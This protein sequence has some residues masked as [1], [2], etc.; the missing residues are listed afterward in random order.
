M[1]L[2]PSIEIATRLTR[3]GKLAEAMA[4][5]TGTAPAGEAGT[6]PQTP[7]EA[8]ARPRRVL[9]A[10]LGTVIGRLA[11]GGSL[12]SRD[13]RHG[14]SP[15]PEG[16]SFTERHM[17]S[18]VGLTYKL[19]IPS[20]AGAEPLPLLV[21]LHGCTQSP[22][23]F[24]AGT[25][26]NERAEAEGFYVAYPAQTRAANAQKCWN[27]FRAVDQGRRGEPALIVAMTGEIM[28]SEN[29]DPTRVYV[30]GLSAGG[31]AAAVLGQ[32]YPEVF[33]AVGVHSGLACGAATD[34]SSAFSAMKGGSVV[35][36]AGA[37][38]PTIVFHGDRD[39][40]VAPINGHQV[41][42]QAKS[43]GPLTAHAETAAAP[44]GVTYTRTI[45][46]DGGG[47]PMSEQWVLHGAGHA[48]SGGDP[49]G[50]YTDPRGPDASLA[51]LRF[52]RQHASSKQPG[53]PTTRQAV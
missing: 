9:E 12:A 24:A 33:A 3:A 49:A 47:R 10:G 41:V 45:Q 48:W 40:T 36:V 53:E 21:M 17:A 37:A 2:L 52:F 8:L 13:S 38:V 35:P 34:M 6:P 44:G 7:R 26:M 20:R 5:L 15:V 43:A 29:V 31:A 42:A 32:N 14:P 27:W 19:F 11:G 18:P 50:S 25:R 22:D 51:M 4:T 46:T 39:G 16:A 28:R 30:A 1:R 23:D